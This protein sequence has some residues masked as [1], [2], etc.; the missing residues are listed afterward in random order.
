MTLWK[1][2]IP[3]K[4]KVHDGI[5]LSY[6]GLSVLEVRVLKSIFTLA[7]QLSENV[8]LTSPGQ[9]AEADVILVNADDPKTLELWNKIKQRNSMCTSLMLS[10]HAESGLGDI[11]LQRP[12]RVQKLIAALEDIVEQT[13]IQ[14]PNA[15]GETELRVLVIDDSFPVRKYMEHKLSELVD[16]P[17]RLY[18]AANGEE[19]IEKL[20]KISC[21][22]IFLDVMMDGV[23]GY[24]VC[25]MIKSKSNPYIVMLTSKKSPFDKVRGTM[26]GCDA[27]ITKPPADERLVEEIRKCIDR[28]HGNGRM[29]VG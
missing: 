8:T 4:I 24:K 28:G 19:A 7:P 16:V 20:T 27:Y 1:S 22:L 23:D 9:V 18:L 3:E 12:I 29:A 25:K 6:L 15:G 26:S 11:T 5:N 17:I 14:I 10:D 13:S 21:D 2:S